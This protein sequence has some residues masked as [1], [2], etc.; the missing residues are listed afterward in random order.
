MKPNTIFELNGFCKSTVD[1]RQTANVVKRGG[2]AMSK[3]M[4]KC[5]MRLLDNQPNTLR[6]TAYRQ[7]STGV[8]AFMVVMTS[9]F[10][11][12]QIGNATI[13]CIHKLTG[14]IGVNDLALYSLLDETAASHEA[15]I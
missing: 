9:V 6:A 5:Q 8:R 3:T 7:L 1:D 15:L 12:F 13:K 14:L 11:C 4:C 10:P 2:L